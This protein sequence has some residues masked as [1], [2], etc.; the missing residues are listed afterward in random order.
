MAAEEL[1]RQVETIYPLLEAGGLV[2]PELA[3]N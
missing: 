1:N 3:R 2:A